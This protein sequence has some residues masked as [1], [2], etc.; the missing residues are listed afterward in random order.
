MICAFYYIINVF[1]MKAAFKTAMFAIC[2]LAMS[3]CSIIRGLRADGMSGPDIYSYKQRV[4]D[5]IANGER[6]FQLPVGKRADWIDT[7]HFYNEPPFCTNSTFVDAISGNEN[8]GVMII[9][10]DS[11]VYERYWGNFNAD[12]LATIFS[13]SKSITSLLCGI[14][15]DE[16]FIHSIDDPVTEYLPELKRKDPMWQKLTIRH[17]LD[18]RSGLDFDDTYEFTSLKDLKMINAMARLNYGH[19]ILK[20]IK[21]L[22]FRCEPGT[23]RRY[24]SM[25]SAILGVVIER[26]TGRR[27]ADY[28]SDKVWKPLGMESPALINI[29]SRKHDVAHNFGGITT[30]LKDLAKIGQLY[31][32]NGMWDGKRIVSEDWI[33]H[34]SEYDASNRGYHYNW[35]NLSYEGFAKAEYPGFYAF[36]ICAQTLYVNPYKNLVMVRMGNSNNSCAYIPE[37]FEQLSNVWPKAL[38]RTEGETFNLTKQGAH[39]V[40]TSSINGQAE[41]TILL[42]SGIPAML[43]DSAYAF[44]KG[45]LSEMELTPTGGKEKLNLGGRVFVITHKAN[46]TVRIG[47]NTS[48]VGEVWVLSNYHLGYDAA[49]PVM[50]LRNDLDGGSRIVG[51]DLANHSLYMMSRASLDAKKKTYSES[52]MNTDTYMGMFAVETNAIID[53]GVKPRTLSGNGIIDFGNPELLFLMHQNEDVQQFLAD[54]AD[55]ELQ[56]ARTPNGDVVAQF[57]LTKECQLCGITFPNAVVAI[58]KNLP[59]ITTPCNIGLKYFEQVEAVLDFDQ[60]VLYT[61]RVSLPQN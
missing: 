9:H 33:R 28:L 22:K 46:G 5:T 19:N 47:N 8:Q 4:V 15:V 12:E 7:L 37:L 23:Q 45:V 43:V 51:L 57:I 14:A 38:D 2:A 42:E 13:I 44:S 52:A 17:L 53:D 48:F 31:L 20:Q 58:T 60:A 34:S 55:L 59:L 1:Y 39:Y 35:Y 56:E 11:I 26:A 21:G 49:L 50:Y 24:E 27:F 30:T 36:G 40:F 3:S 32:N 10:N 18:M 6:Y 29:D 54:N 61:K 41:A 25:T 16:G